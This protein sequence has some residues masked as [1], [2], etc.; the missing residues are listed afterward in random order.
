MLDA[1]SA[2]PDQVDAPRAVSV[3]ASLEAEILALRHQLNVLRREQTHHQVGIGVS[4]L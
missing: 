3:E 2:Q 4:S 1:G